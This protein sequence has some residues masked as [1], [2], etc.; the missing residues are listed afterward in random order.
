M[1]VILL[2]FKFDASLY[3]NLKIENI[4]EINNN[5][6]LLHEIDKL[7]KIVNQLHFDFVLL[8]DEELKLCYAI[9]HKKV[10]LQKAKSKAVELKAKLTQ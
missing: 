5:E 10:K 7:E 8:D 4:M 6:R 9:L 2:H 3:N 1:L